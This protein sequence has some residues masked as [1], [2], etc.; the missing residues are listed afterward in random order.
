VGA[1]SGRGATWAIVGFL[2]LAAVLVYLLGFG[3]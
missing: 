1:G 3:R 2:M